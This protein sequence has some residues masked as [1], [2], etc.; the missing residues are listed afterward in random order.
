MELVAVVESME[1]EV[2]ETMTMAVAM[3]VAVI[4]EFRVFEN[5]QRKTREFQHF[6]SFFCLTFYLL[7]TYIAMIYFRNMFGDSLMNDE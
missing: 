4:T 7:F 3:T 6:D 1:A 2:V 5:E